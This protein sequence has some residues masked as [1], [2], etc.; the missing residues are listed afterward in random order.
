LDVSHAVG[1]VAGWGALAENGPTSTTLQAVKVPILT[2]ERCLMSEYSSVEVTPNM[3]CAG[4]LENG[5]VDSCKGDSGG[6]LL[7]ED[8]MMRTIAAGKN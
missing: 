2:Q 6:S 5:G 4:N 7:I 1:T 8:S 3:F